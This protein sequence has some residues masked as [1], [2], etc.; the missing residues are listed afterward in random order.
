M[1]GFFKAI[2]AA[3]VAFMISGGV[4]GAVDMTPAEAV[5]DFMAGLTSGDKQVLE[6]Y[7]DND[8]VNYL[9]NIEG[10]EE[11]IARMD[12]AIFQNLTYKETDKAEKK[13]VAVV[14]LKVKTND[15]SKVMDAYEKASYKYVMDNLYED[16]V[17]DKKKLSAK[18]LDI[19]VEQIEKA[20]EKE[21]TLEKKIYLP[22]ISDGYGGWKMV[23][24]DKIMKA[25]MGDLA[26][27]K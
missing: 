11:L 1:F 7:I 14:E 17:T 2:I 5:D 6:Q 23:L 24:N 9:V 27:P 18:C 12:K 15:F 10:D 13:G 16:K 26:L 4:A 19:Y 8:Y 25:L 3:F 22:M 21:P 20:A